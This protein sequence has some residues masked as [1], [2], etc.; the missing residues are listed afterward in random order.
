MTSDDTKYYG[1]EIPFGSTPSL[2]LVVSEETSESFTTQDDLMATQCS[3]RDLEIGRSES[4]TR[5]ASKFLMQLALTG[6]I[7][8]G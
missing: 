2:A 5:F 4:S 8:I 6:K 3:E 1:M 7:E